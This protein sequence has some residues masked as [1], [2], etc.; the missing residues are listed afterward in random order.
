MASEADVQALGFCPARLSRLRDHMAAMV[1]QGQVAGVSTLLMRH[2][3][4]VARQIVGRADLDAGR[5]LADDTLFRIYSMTK[6]VVTVALMTLFEEARFTLDDPITR[7]LPEFAELRV[8]VGENPDGSMRTKPARR[9]PTMRELMSHT[10][11]LGYGLFDHHPVE[12]AYRAAGV[13]TASSLDDFAARA[14]S[15]PLM[16]HPGEEWFYSVG[17]GLQGLVIERITG[18]SLGDALRER[19]FDPLGM[20]ATGFQ[21]PRDD[22]NRMATLYAQTPGGELVPAGTI[23]DIPVH[24]VDQPP[25]FEDGGGGLV[26]TLDDYGRFAQMVLNR[27]GLDGRRI[28]A[29][30]TVEL[31]ATNMIPDA[32]LA[33]PSPLRLLPFQP[34]FGFGL[35]FSIMS[36]PRRMGSLE[37]RGTLAWGGGGGT[38]FWVDPENDVVF[39]G[40]I[41]RVADPVSDAFRKAARVLTYQALIRP[42]L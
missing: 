28:L 37:G 10:S 34:A 11:G 1:E 31:M 5:P 27:G 33:R 4:V 24:P 13:M 42:D 35:G 41:Q 20:N 30:A 6:P 29:P 36:D 18:R 17:S 12:R 32:V 25:P 14:A 3:R 8:C 40:M 9:P 21:I 15:I 19:V 38:W 22:A 7:F 26:S 2:G 39:V 16:F 23:F